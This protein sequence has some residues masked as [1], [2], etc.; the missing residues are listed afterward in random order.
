MHMPN[1]P[2]KC[3]TDVVEK[4]LG[5]YPSGKIWPMETISEGLSGATV[6]LVHVKA[7]SEQAYNG[8]A[9]AKVDGENRTREE[10]QRHL[11]ALTEATKAFIPGLLCEPL[12]PVNGY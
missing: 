2:T 8:L 4:L 9:F 1:I 5:L 10:Y 7:T 11:H 12:G 3:P 6:L